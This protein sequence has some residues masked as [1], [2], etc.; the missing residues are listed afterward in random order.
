MA[1]SYT[2]RRSVDVLTCDHTSGSQHCAWGPLRSHPAAR[3]E[4]ADVV[5]VVTLLNVPDHRVAHRIAGVIH[6][7]F[8]RNLAPLALDRYP[9]AV[10]ADVVRGVMAVGNIAARHAVRAADALEPGPNIF[11]N[12]VV[13]AV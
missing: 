12:F 8:R 13:L 11:G 2:R 5:G 10:A 9:V 1:E 4:A 6:D 7:G 3:N